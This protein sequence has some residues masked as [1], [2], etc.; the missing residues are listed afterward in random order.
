[1]SGAN[2]HTHYT[3]MLAVDGTG[4]KETW[5]PGSPVEIIRWGYIAFALVDV[6]TECIVVMDKTNSGGTRGDGD[7]GS[8]STGSTDLAAQDGIY[9]E[10]VSPGVTLHPTEPHKLIPGE[11]V[12]IQ[13]TDAADTSG[14]GYF[15]IE[16]R[17]L[18]FVGDSA[19][20]DD[21][22]ANMLKVTS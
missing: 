12:T 4:D 8:I 18:P 3:A 15:F 22:L 2:Y 5:C 1:M 9:T 10:N 11:S 14:D 21:G 13:V 16:Y 7:V 19:S 20:G 17:K 6:G